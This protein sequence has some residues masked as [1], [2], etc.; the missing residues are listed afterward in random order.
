[1][2][3]TLFREKW[4]DDKIQQDMDVIC[5]E[6]LRAVRPISILL[7]GAFGRGGKELK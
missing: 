7:T 5:Q 2:S 3:Y 1:M 6:I 4:V